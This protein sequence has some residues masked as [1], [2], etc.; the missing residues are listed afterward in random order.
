MDLKYAIFPRSSITV[1]RLMA[2]HNIQEVRLFYAKFKIELLKCWIWIGPSNFTRRNVSVYLYGTKN[3]TYFTF[4]QEPAIAGN[5]VATKFLQKCELFVGSSPRCNM[6]ETSERS[7]T[8]NWQGKA[9]EL[10]IP[11]PLTFLLWLI[12]FHST[13]RQPNR[14]IISLHVV[15]SFGRHSRI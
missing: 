4:I 13:E 7:S 10:S 3:G 5:K 8:S 2:C 9:N 1:Q 6:Q 11:P 15:L 14:D 12:S